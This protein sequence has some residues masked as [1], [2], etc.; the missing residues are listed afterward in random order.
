MPAFFEARLVPT[1]FCNHE[2]VLFVQRRNSYAQ[3]MQFFL[4]YFK[5]KVP[6]TLIVVISIEPPI[7][8]DTIYGS[9]DAV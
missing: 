5:D 4:S 9:A 8:P 6:H 7:S 2:L 3:F 1:L